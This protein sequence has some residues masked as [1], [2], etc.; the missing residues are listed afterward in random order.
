MHA[1]ETDWTEK[2]NSLRCALC[3]LDVLKPKGI[4]SVPPAPLFLSAM[5]LLAVGQHG[6]DVLS[7]HAQQQRSFSGENALT[8]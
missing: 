4:R 7:A 6:K 5:R 8:M 1:A 3:R 2:T